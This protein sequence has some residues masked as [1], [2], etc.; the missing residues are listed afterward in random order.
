MWRIILI[1]G[2][3][4][5]FKT[6]IPNALL[7]R[8]I[9]RT[10]TTLASAEDIHRQIDT[11]NAADEVNLFYT[12]AFEIKG[13]TSDRQFG[14]VDLARKL[15]FDLRFINET[16]IILP[17]KLHIPYTGVDIEF[18]VKNIIAAS[19]IDPKDSRGKPLLATLRG[20]GGG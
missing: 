7:L 2:R 6:K 3:D 19:E 13:K 16:A 8:S 20:V 11:L 17:N 18:I 5:A 9:I 4:T 10:P 1:N 12:T 14:G 15:N